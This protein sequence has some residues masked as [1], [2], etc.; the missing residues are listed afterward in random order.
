LAVNP[1]DRANAASK[2][3]F[4]FVDLIRFLFS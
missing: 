1:K 2:I 4:M 3:L